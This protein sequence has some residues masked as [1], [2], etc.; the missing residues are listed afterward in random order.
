MKFKSIAH[1]RVDLV[2]YSCSAFIAIEVTVESPGLVKTYIEK[3]KPLRLQNNHRIKVNFGDLLCSW[4]VRVEAKVRRNS[5]VLLAPYS[6]QY[7]VEKRETLVSHRLSSKRYSHGMP[8]DGRLANPTVQSQRALQVHYPIWK[9][10]MATTWRT[11]DRLFKEKDDRHVGKLEF[12]ITDIH[13]QSHHHSHL[14]RIPYTII[15][16]QNMRSRIPI[17]SRAA[18]KAQRLLYSFF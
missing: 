14:P 16:Q 4:G 18:Y 1:L 6:N 3:R 5:F 12:P 11:P 7:R 2:K 9:P 10:N 8:I 17:L 15:R 13:E